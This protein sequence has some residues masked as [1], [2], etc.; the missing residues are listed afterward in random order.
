MALMLWNVH[1]HSV[2]QV[3]DVDQIMQRLKEIKGSGA[4]FEMKLF[5]VDRV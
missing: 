5:S 3:K 2:L 4:K 1:E